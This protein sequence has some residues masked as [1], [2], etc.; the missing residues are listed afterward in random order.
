MKE[1]NI[2]FIYDGTIEGI[3]TIVYKCMVDK[4]IPLDIVKDKVKLNLFD[5]YVVI[6]T[7]LDISNKIFNSIPKRM[8]DITLYNVYNAF[9]SNKNDKEI[10]IVKYLINGYKYGKN[11][12]RMKTIDSVINIEKYSQ[13]VRREAHKLK[14][15]IRFE[16]VDGI[17]YSIISPE[18]DVLEILIPHFK[19]RLKNEMWIIEDVK[20]KKAI[21]YNKKDYKVIDTTNM[22]LNRFLKDGNDKEYKDLWKSFIKSITIK[23]RKNLRCQMNFMPKRYWKYMTEMEDDDE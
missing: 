17:L 7:D 13:M 22:N 14:G 20:R 9:L 10:N 21:F 6:N 12:S 11:I 15:F 1:S 19:N 3:F 4:I 16:E 18:H 2:V 23:E 8:G 5:D